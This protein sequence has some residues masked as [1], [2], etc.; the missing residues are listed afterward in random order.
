MRRA[1]A[2]LF[3]LFAPPAFASDAD[4][5]KLLTYVRWADIGMPGSVARLR[6]AEIARLRRCDTWSM[7]FTPAG[8]GIDQ[9]FVVGM[10]MGTTFPKVEVSHLAGETIFILFKDVSTKTSDTLH[11][12]QDGNVLT[13]FSPPFRPHT[14]LRCPDTPE[15]KQR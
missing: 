6:P 8:A 7:Y 12:S 14:Y 5:I 4:D 10:T 2:C 3:L 11:L 15:K 1:L 9:I 13:Q